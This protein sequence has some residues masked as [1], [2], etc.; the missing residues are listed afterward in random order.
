M[1]AYGVREMRPTLSPNGGRVAPP[2]ARRGPH[3]SGR[4]GF[5]HPALRDTDLLRGADHEWRRQRVMLQEAAH[6]RPGE[7]ALRAPAELPVPR[8][9]DQVVKGPEAV[10]IAHA[11]EVAVVTA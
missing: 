1:G 9:H 6:G 2:V 5:P 7:T 3:R 11:V 4:A 10:T 8:S